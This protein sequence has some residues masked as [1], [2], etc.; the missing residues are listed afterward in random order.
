MGW[1][2]WP[3]DQALAADVN[4]VSMAIAAKVDLLIMQSGG[5]K[6]ADGQGKKGKNARK[7]AAE[8]FKKFAQSTQ[9]K[10]DSIDG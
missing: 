8:K 3:P 5:K 6:E 1:L 7:R 4:L 10:R 9:A 2:G